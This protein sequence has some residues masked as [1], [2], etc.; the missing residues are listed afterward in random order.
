MMTWRNMTDADLPAIKRVADIVHQDFPESDAVFEERLRLYAAGC[1]VLGNDERTAGY[2]VS[3]PWLYGRPP[4]LN[5]LL[6]AIPLKAD[7]YYIH[8]IALL[9]EAR[10]SGSASGIVQTLVDH[11]R[12]ESFSNL[13]LIAVSG[14]APFWQ[15]RGFSIV[16]DPDIDGK[17][18]SYGR[19]AR[20]MTLQV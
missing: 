18:Q 5:S 17:L 3:H 6:Q 13:S 9:D 14:S 16:S 20:F 4:A 1:F 12:G 8:D 10:R 2:A 19:D 7:T 15:T 11:A